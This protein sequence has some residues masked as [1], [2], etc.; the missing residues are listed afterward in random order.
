MALHCNSDALQFWHALDSCPPQI[1]W[2]ASLGDI[3]QKHPDLV[4]EFCGALVAD[5]AYYTCV[6]LL[7]FL[8]HSKQAWILLAHGLLEPHVNS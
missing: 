6:L 3:P 5:H 4:A 8:C 2:A 7:L 1:E